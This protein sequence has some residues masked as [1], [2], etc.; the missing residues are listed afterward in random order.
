MCLKETKCKSMNSIHVAHTSVHPCV[1]LLYKKSP[2][3]D[4]KA[5][6]YGF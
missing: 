5:L 2:L 3:P 4:S 1:M 6:V